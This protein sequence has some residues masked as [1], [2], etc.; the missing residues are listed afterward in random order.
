MALTEDWLLQF[1]NGFRYDPMNFVKYGAGPEAALVRAVV[2]GRPA[3]G[4]KVLLRTRFKEII[5][6]LSGLDLITS[7]RI[8][9]L[10]DLGLDDGLRWIADNMDDAGCLGCWDPWAVLDRVGPVDHPV[11]REI[12]IRQ[13]PMIL[14]AQNV[15]GGWGSRSFKVFRALHTHGLFDELRALPPLPMDWEIVRSVRAPEGELSTLVWD[16]GRFW[17][18]NRASNEAIA[19]SPADGS[20]EI[21]L[22]LPFERVIGL[23]MW[24]D[25]LAVTAAGPKRIAKV[26]PGSG[27]V[28]QEIDI[29]GLIAPA[30]AAEVD[31]SIFVCDTAVMDLW[32]IDLADPTSRKCA[33]LC[34][35]SP[36]AIAPAGKSVWCLDCC[37]PGIY[38]SSLGGRLI[39]WGD[40]PFGDSTAGLAWDGKRLWAL[41]ARNRRVCQISR[42]ERQ[43][44]RTR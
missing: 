41:D 42:R 14:R 8:G 11:A 30:P 5:A 29:D 40:K 22:K 6:D 43:K 16:G 9:D 31:G 25:G 17:T 32:R 12:V 20:I 4:D 24:G 33:S 21:T 15:S 10:L 38:R 18:L 7:S 44:P 28:V 36:W 23:G 2:F 1:E 39:E 34:A 26:S 3:S 19:I 27:K 13:L 37:S 35:P